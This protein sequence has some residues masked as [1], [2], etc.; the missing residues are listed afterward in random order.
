VKE[1]N[2][3]YQ[4]EGV[5]YGKPVRIVIGKKGVNKDKTFEFHSVIL[6][7]RRQYKD[8]TY[9]ELPEF[10]LGKGVSL[11]N[12]EIGD[13]VIITFALAGKR[14]SADFHKTQVKAL[15]IKHADVE[16]T[17]EIGGK[18]PSEY[19]KKEEVFVVPNPYNGKDDEDLD[20]INLPF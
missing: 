18:T 4:I 6:E 3:I 19:A 20:S 14:I 1:K 16:D 12:F 13:R 9:S 17:T 5:L 15:Y 8:K 2:N 10:D 7:V 11:D